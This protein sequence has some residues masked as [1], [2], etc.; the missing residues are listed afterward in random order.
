MM[1]LDVREGRAYG[2]M[3]AAY[4]RRA[5]VAAENVDRIAQGL[6]PK[7]LVPI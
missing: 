2:T 4:R 5:E 7:Y 6:E 1:V 3:S